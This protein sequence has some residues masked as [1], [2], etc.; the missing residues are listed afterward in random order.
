MK[1]EV[2]AVKALHGDEAY[3]VYCKGIESLDDWVYQPYLLGIKPDDD[4]DIVLPFIEYLNDKYNSVIFERQSMIDLQRKQF[5][6][7]SVMKIRFLDFNDAQDYAA[8]FS[9]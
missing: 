9:S 8:V 4:G 6:G 5:T 1:Y 3:E 2:R 7:K